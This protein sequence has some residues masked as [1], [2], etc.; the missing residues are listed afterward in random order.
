VGT[1]KVDWSPSPPHDMILAGCHDGTVALWNF[2][3]NPSSQD[4]KPF[5]CVTAE[6]GP[7]RALCWAPY[8]S[9]NIN[10]F[11]TAGADGV[12]FWDLR[13]VNTYIRYTNMCPWRLISA[14]L[15]NLFFL[16]KKIS[17]SESSLSYTFIIVCSC[18]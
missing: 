12:K 1:D 2:S 16:K 13:Y 9:E 7:I 3:T 5:M 4:S 10:T 11:V 14:H 6:S 8:I 15:F 18:L 17:L